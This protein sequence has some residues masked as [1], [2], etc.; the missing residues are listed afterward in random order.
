MSDDPVRNGW[1]IVLGVMFSPFV[2]DVA[3]VLSILRSS[4]ELEAA[5]GDVCLR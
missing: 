3:L 1:D 2:A 4:G 5:S